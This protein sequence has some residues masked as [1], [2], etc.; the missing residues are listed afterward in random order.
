MCKASGRPVPFSAALLALGGGL[1]LFVP[2]AGAGC[3]IGPHHPIVAAIEAL[4]ER[5]SL[6]LGW[7]TDTAALRGAAASCRRRSQRPQSGTGS[8]RAG[9][10]TRRGLVIDLSRTRRIPAPLTCLDHQVTKSACAAASVHLRCTCPWSAAAWRRGRVRVLAAASPSA[11]D[12]MSARPSR[13]ACIGSRASGGTC[14]I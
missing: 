5:P 4:T 10:C 11:R 13:F 9:Q 8:G 14:L 3:R 12:L 1:A 2:A 7:K 6:P